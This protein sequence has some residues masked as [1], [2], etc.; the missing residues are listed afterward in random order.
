MDDLVKR[1]RD[2]CTAGHGCARMKNEA[3]AEIERLRKEVERLAESARQTEDEFCQQKILKALTAERDDLRKEVEALRA[4][5]TSAHGAF[6]VLIQ[7]ADDSD[8][9]CYGTLSTSL[10]R[11]VI[12]QVEGRYTQVE[13]DAADKRADERHD[14][15]NIV[16]AAMN[17]K[18]A[19]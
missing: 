1:L 10:V 4:A 6:S 14:R 3:A 5:L 9:H 17:G 13:L 15:L 16:D 8:D 2:G 7:Y 18:G 12:G 19:A 11:A